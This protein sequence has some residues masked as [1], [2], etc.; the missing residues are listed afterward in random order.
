VEPLAKALVSAG[1]SVW[2][3]RNLAGGSR[4]LNETEAEPKA[5]KAAG[6]ACD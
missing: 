2:R 5:A 1:Y 4:Y 3:D 6:Y